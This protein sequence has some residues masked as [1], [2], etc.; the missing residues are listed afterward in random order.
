MLL[1]DSDSDFANLL[2]NIGSGDFNGSCFI[3][4]NKV[5]HFFP[6]KYLVL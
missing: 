5:H 2:G 6:F 4:R 1:F 3:I